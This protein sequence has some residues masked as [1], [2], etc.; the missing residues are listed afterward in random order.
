LNLI[1]S[2]N[3]L[4]AA[5]DTDCDTFLR[6]RIL[7]FLPL[8][9]H[10]STHRNLTTSKKGLKGQLFVIVVCPAQNINEEL[11]LK[12]DKP[13]AGLGLREYLSVHEAGRY[14]TAVLRKLFGWGLVFNEEIRLQAP[15]Q[16][17]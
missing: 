7:G 17:D 8:K 15:C 11:S 16:F 6:L 4:Q 10:P 13:F 14:L 12:P 1:D 9:P 2:H 3:Y 5:C